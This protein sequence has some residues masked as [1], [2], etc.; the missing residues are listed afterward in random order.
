[1]ARKTTTAAET[2]D[3]PPAEAPDA[4]LAAPEPPLDPIPPYVPP[5]VAATVP[6]AE[7]EAPPDLVAL[8]TDVRTWSRRRDRAKAELDLAQGKLDDAMARL[9]EYTRPKP[10]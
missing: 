8:T 6:A 4:E 1:M 10:L 9:H 5:S 7:P 2:A 3:P